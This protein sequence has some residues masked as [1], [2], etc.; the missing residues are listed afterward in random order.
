MGRLSADTCIWPLYEVVDGNYRITYRPKAKKP[1]TDW[2]GVQGRF[3]HLL[4][5]ENKATIDQIQAFTDK[6]WED[7]LKKEASSVQPAKPAETAKPA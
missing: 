1:V 3:R 7:L 4:K 2:I 5:P 6:N